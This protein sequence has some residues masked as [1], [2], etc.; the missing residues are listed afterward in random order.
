[1]IAA[2]TVCMVAAEIELKFRVRDAAEFERAVIA[3]GFQ[4]VTPRTLE[5][6]TLYDTPER[7]LRGRREVLRIRQYGDSCVVTHK[8]PTDAER[9]QALARYKFRQESETEVTDPDAMGAIF[10]EMGYVPVFCYEKYR[11]EFVDGAGKLVLDETPIGVFAEAEGEPEWIDR[12]V[13]LLG[14]SE[15]DCFTDS[16]G[17][18]FEIWQTETGS[19]VRDMT[20][21][22]VNAAAV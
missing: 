1:M 12:T 17:R 5:R 7:S 18:L 22:D 10:K 19:N 15:A 16:Y 21:E 14:V 6:N 11:T 9:E 4:L 13:A 8:K 20:F 3:A 2:Y